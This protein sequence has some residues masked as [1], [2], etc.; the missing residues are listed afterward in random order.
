MGNELIFKQGKK[1]YKRA[2]KRVYIL[3][4]SPNRDT[5]IL[6]EDIQAQEQ[7]QGQQDEEDQSED[8]GQ[9]EEQ[10]KGGETQDQEKPSQEDNEGEEVNKSLSSYKF[11][12]EI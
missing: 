11:S 4:C 8:Y 9:E 12:I 10:E 5:Y 3:N 2:P 7:G 1:C 6:L